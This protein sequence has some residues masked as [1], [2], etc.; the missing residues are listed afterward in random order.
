MRPR[1]QKRVN[2]QE[3]VEALEYKRKQYSE[4]IGQIMLEEN[5]SYTQAKTLLQSRLRDKVLSNF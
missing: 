5:V 2:V 4:T 3:V 1:I